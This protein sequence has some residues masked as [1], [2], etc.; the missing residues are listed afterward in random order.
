MN[1]SSFFIIGLV[2]F[3]FY[4]L[5]T[6]NSTTDKKVESKAK[7]VEESDGKPFKTIL[8]P[9][10]LP[11]NQV[12]IVAPPNCPSDAS[13]RAR[14]IEEYLKK[15]KVPYVRTG[16]INFGALNREDYNLVRSIMGGQLPIVMINSKAK[17]N[18]TIK[19]TIL[20]YRSHFGRGY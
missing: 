11:Y 15:Y 3:G 2:A 6:Q 18:P 20:E 8:V 4:F 14:K 17:N 16:E 13:K 9:K 12:I 7:I 19:E 5:Q 10:G 1:S